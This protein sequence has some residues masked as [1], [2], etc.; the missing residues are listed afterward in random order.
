M[1]R[2][3]VFSVALSMAVMIVATS[4]LSGF[5]IQLKEKIS[6]FNSH[7]R[8][9][10]L[11]SNYSFDTPPVRNDYDF[12]HPITV[13]PVVRHIQQYAYKGG[14]IR[15]NNDI[16]GVVLK[17]VGTDFDWSFFEQ[18]I[19]EGNLFSVNDSVSSDSVLISIPDA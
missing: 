7:V 12:Y 5:K 18:Y 10:N 3:A 4:V 13:L 9:T 19:V 6:G 11:D 8:I 17:G 2:I 14:I 1:T 15:A 16:Q